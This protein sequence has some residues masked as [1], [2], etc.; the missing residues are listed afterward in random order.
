MFFILRLS[1][2]RYWERLYQPETDRV[3][4]EL[5]KERNLDNEKIPKAEMLH[6]DGTVC[7]THIDIRHLCPQL[8]PQPLRS[9][10][11]IYCAKLQLP[12]S[13]CPPLYNKDGEHDLWRTVW[14]SGQ[15]GV[16]QSA[17]RGARYYDTLNRF[18]VPVS[19]PYSLKSLQG[20]ARTTSVRHHS[21]LL[22]LTFWSRNF[23]LKF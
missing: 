2:F 13:A 15:R 9:G 12:L 22:L 1:G 21:F 11:T 4:K 20:D 14:I 8:E 19:R 5:K 10:A 7:V 18:P 6:E 17:R 23:T 3:S 16:S